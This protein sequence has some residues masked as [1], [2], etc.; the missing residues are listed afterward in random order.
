MVPLVEFLRY[1]QS[2]S[3]KDWSSRR[4]SNA[5]DFVRI[6]N[7]VAEAEVGV[8]AKRLNAQLFGISSKSTEKMVASNTKTTTRL[9]RVD[10]PPRS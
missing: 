6:D 9:Q 4:D 7:L 3:R 1:L 5:D 2:M 10:E 8:G